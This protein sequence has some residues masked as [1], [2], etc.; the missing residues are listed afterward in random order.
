MTSKMSPLVSTAGILLFGNLLFQIFASHVGRKRGIRLTSATVR[1]GEATPVSAL[2][3][4]LYKFQRQFV[5][6]LFCALTLGFPELLASTAFGAAFCAGI[7]VYLGLTVLSLTTK[8]D[9]PRPMFALDTLLYLAPALCY[10]LSAGV[11]LVI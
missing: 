4:S 10:A 6:F 5:T 3:A 7:A 11:W 2:T 8:T 1:P 9:A